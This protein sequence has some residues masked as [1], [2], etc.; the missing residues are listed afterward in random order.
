MVLV[1]FINK[2]NCLTSYFKV[3]SHPKC[4]HFGKNNYNSKINLTPIFVLKKEIGK[5]MVSTG[6][7][8]KKCFLLVEC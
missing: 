4:D 2:K 8:G 3:A 7:Y 5:Y 1:P 6:S